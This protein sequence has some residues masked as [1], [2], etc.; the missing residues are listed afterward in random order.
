[1]RKIE[2][3]SRGWLCAAAW[4]LVATSGCGLDATGTG[5]PS[6]SSSGSVAS[7]SSSS[8]LG[9]E[10]GTGGLGGAGGMS[11][12]S[13]SGSGGASADE[14]CTDGTDNDADGSIDCADTKDCESL[15]SCNA[16]APNPWSYVRIRQTTFGGTKEPCGGGVAPQVLYEGEDFGDCNKCSCNAPGKC[17]ITMTCY[18]NDNCTGMQ[19]MAKYSTDADGCTADATAA[20]GGSCQLTGGPTVPMNAVCNSGGGGLKNADPWKNEVHVCTALSNASGCGADACVLA[21]AP[22][23][24]TRL[25]VSRVGAQQCP[26][27][28]GERHLAYDSFNDTRACSACSCNA[29]A[30]SCAGSSTVTLWS[31]SIC[32]QNAHTVGTNS[33]CVNVPLGIAYRNVTGIPSM[34]VNN[35]PPSTPTG[36]VVGAGATTICC[37]PP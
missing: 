7:G 17:E 36:S 12:S 33:G 4:T 31:N 13:S 25:C 9:G 1:M 18:S 22:A 23:Y 16:P 3:L 37:P 32:T 8:G 10:G 20:A 29:G 26:A 6:G 19:A 27:G 30:I 21:P 2:M 15:F 24:E 5:Q 14:N 28:Y 11:S 34:T 35:C